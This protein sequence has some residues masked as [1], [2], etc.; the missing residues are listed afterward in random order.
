ML[1]EIARLS[2]ET[3]VA[4]LR[5]MDYPVYEGDYNLNLIG[6]RA[7]DHDSNA[8]NDA[9]IVLYMVSGRWHLHYFPFTTDPGEHYR[10][11]PINSLGT[12][13]LVPGHYPGC[14]RIGSHQGKYRAL[15]QCGDVTVYRDENKDASLDTDGMQTQ[16]GQFGINLHRAGENITSQE[17]NRWSAGCQV[18]PSPIHFDL[19]MALVAVSAD[20][21]G[22][23]FSY[24]LLTEGELCSA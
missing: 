20:R 1:A 9:L 6:V 16:T 12:A 4:L 14:W 21:Y 22:A 19:L 2:P 5:A 11:N 10:E 8:F 17:V 24:T 18:V 13:V 15:V 3:L 23:Y 7:A